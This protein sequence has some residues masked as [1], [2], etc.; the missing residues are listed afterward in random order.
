MVSQLDK[1]AADQHITLFGL[2]PPPGHRACGRPGIGA[3]A[4][5]PADRL[6]R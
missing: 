5:G 3:D 6:R 1:N 2:K 4:A